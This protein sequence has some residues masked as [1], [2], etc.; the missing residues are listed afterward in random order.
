MRSGSVHFDTDADWFP[1]LQSEMLRFPRDINDD[2]V[3]ALAW[4]GLT[5]DQ[6]IVP[7][8][9]KELQDEYYDEMESF[10]PAGRSLVTGY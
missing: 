10:M 1:A 2:Q 5:L 7:Q 9:D 4:I 6:L 3:D 8:T